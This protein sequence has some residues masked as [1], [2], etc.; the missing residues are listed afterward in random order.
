MNNFYHSQIALPPSLKGYFG[1][2]ESKITFHASQAQKS[3]RY[4]SFNYPHFFSI[5]PENVI[6]VEQDSTG[7]I[8]KILIR[9]KYNN[10][11]DLCLAIIPADDKAIIKTGW[12]NKSDDT[13]KTLD[14]TKYIH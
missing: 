6:E 8:V 11:F 9:V 5:K 7:K 12:L 10:I 3:D 13:H 4:G 14:V 1:Q 2:Y